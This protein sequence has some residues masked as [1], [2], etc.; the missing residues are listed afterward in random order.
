MSPQA[1]MD[2]MFVPPQ[3]LPALPARGGLFSRKLDEPSNE[4]C[5]NGWFNSMEFCLKVDN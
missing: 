2:C 1:G 5:L 4:M 3:D